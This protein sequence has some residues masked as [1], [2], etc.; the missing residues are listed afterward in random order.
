[1]AVKGRLLLEDNFQRYATYGKV[2]QPVAGAWTVQTSHAEW[3]RSSDGVESVWTAGHMP[4]LKYNGAFGDAVIEVDFRFHAQPGKW[5]GC[6]VSATNQALNPRAYAVSTWANAN[7][8]D[9]KHGLVLEH[10]EWKPGAITTVDLKPDTFAPDTWYTL[11]LEI[12]GNHA[13]ATC[14]GVTVYGTFEKF[15]LP[16]TSIYLGTG[17][18][19]HELRNF[20]VYAATPNSSWVPP[21]TFVTPPA[22]PAPAG[23][24][25]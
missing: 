1:M 9:R 4:V 17:T 20:R 12:I 10:D 13:L 6:R 19:P 21:T 11:R 5:G 2:P 15:G 24:A 16:K 7:G 14:N 18:C 22:T 8:P 3:R 23:L 25:K